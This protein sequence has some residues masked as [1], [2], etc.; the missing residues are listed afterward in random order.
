[1]SRSV[2]NCG[3]ITPFFNLHEAGGLHLRL[4]QSF[5]RTAIITSP[6]SNPRAM[7]PVVFSAS[8]TIV[9]LDE[10]VVFLLASSRCSVS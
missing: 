4:A 9:V 3:W 2:H 8:T 6:A 5:L 1:M 10:G 7:N